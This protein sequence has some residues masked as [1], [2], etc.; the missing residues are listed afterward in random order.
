[1]LDRPPPTASLWNRARNLGRNTAGPVVRTG[2]ELIQRYGAIG[3]TSRAARGFGRFGDGSIVTFPYEAIVNPHAIS[4]GCD[5]V[6]GKWCVLSAGWAPEHRHLPPD[7]LT[8]GDR[9]LIGRG[10]SIVAHRSIV[11]DDDVWTGQQVHLTDMNHGYVD[12][13]LPL[14]KQGSPPEPIHI[15][16]GAWLGHG[17]V[18]LPGV[19]IGRNCAVGAGS[20]VT[21][22]LPD[23]SVAVGIPARVVK[24]YDPEQG[25]LDVKPG[26]PPTPST[27]GLAGLMNEFR[28]LGPPAGS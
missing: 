8:I 28:K 5:T 9:C 11:I 10:S 14:S 1:M 19:T 24:Q 26:R 7:M 18:V 20:V 2:W 3:P 15:R 16:A 27:E 25:W 22:D 12:V 21:H 13:S 17:V 4:I 23:Y 6:I